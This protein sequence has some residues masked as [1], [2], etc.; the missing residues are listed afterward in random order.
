MISVVLAA[1]SFVFILIPSCVL[2][3]D[4]LKTQYLLILCGLCIFTGIAALLD[5]VSRYKQIVGIKEDC[6]MDHCES[7][8]LISLHFLSIS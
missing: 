5:L 4:T 2:F 8:T 3:E 6:L 1:I 7:Y